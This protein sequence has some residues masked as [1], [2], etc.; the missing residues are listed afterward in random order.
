MKYFKSVIVMFS[1]GLLLDCRLVFGNEITLYDQIKE[2]LE[3]DHTRNLE[4]TPRVVIE[5]ILKQM[6][7]H[8][9]YSVKDFTNT[10]IILNRVLFS[11]SCVGVMA[12]VGIPLVFISG[13]KNDVYIELTQINI[14]IEKILGLM[15]E[16]EKCDKVISKEEKINYLINKKDIHFFNPRE[17]FER[18]RFIQL[19]EENLIYIFLK[20]KDLL[21]YSNIFK[22]DMVDALFWSCN[23]NDYKWSEFEFKENIRTLKIFAR[24]LI[25]RIVLGGEQK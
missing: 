1:L 13:M 24:A 20:E 3:V 14:I 5:S 7:F 10:K 23:D 19:L 6:Y 9:N 15:I 18:E 11:V 16:E 21:K 22:T 2:V 4:K 8:S 12:L 25:D 17:F